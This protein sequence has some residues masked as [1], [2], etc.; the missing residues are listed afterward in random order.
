MPPIAT[1][2]AAMQRRAAKCR[3]FSADVALGR[4]PVIR[5]PLIIQVSDASD[6]RGVALT[7]CPIDCFSLRFEGRECVVRMVF[8][9]IIVDTGPF[10]AALGARFNVNVRHDLLF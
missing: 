7:F 10:R 6:M 4:P 2:V 5:H 8:H 1:A 9:D 3:K